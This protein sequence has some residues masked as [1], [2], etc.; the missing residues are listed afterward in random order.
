MDASENLMI[1]KNAYQRWIAKHYPVLSKIELWFENSAIPG[2]LGKA[3]NQATG[4]E[5]YYLWS[6]DLHQAILVTRQPNDLIIKLSSPQMSL[7]QATESIRAD[8]EPV[9]EATAANAAILR[10][11]RFLIDSHV[12][13]GGMDVD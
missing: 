6:H 11:D 9:V 7:S 10:N 13:A 4:V 2:Y 1:A 8:L 12:A 5:E 3:T